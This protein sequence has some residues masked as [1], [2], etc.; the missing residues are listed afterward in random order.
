MDNPFFQL[1]NEMA[2]TLTIIKWML[3]CSVAMSFVIVVRGWR[4]K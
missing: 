4:R 3:Y 1:F 2:I